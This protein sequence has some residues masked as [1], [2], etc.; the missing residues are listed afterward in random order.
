MCFPKNK[1][2]YTSSADIELGSL[3]AESKFSSNELSTV[4]S[5]NVVIDD[6]A[7]EML[8]PIVDGVQSDANKQYKTQ[9]ESNI[10]AIGN[11]TTHSTG[12]GSD[13]SQVAQNTLDIAD[14]EDA[15]VEIADYPSG[16]AIT[17]DT[18]TANATI[19]ATGINAYDELKLV[20]E[21]FANEKRII[22][23]DIDDTSTF[24]SY[25]FRKS[26]SSTA[27]GERVSRMWNDGGSLKGY[28]SVS[29]TLS[30]TPTITIT[31]T[32]GNKVYKVYGRVR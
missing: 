24:G 18:S 31:T 19:I 4:G 28:Y 1:K 25:T 22:Y 27:D 6:T 3:Y 26:T 16:L 32:T 15:W 30:T 2:H 12:D 5:E 10:T 20:V 9:I 11:N 14:K 17:D 23:F 13:H 21:G 7:N 29:V 8:T